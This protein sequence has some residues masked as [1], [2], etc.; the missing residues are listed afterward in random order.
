MGRKIGITRYLEVSNFEHQK[1]RLLSLMDNLRETYANDAWDVE[2]NC[3]TGNFRNTFDLV[4]ALHQ[5][6]LR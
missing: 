3:R 4:S 2:V 5:R 6:P 1:K